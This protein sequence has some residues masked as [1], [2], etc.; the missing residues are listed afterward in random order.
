LRAELDPQ[1]LCE[2]TAGSI[3]ACLQCWGKLVQEKSW[4][5]LTSPPSLRES[6]RSVTASE[7]RQPLTSGIYSHGHTLYPST[8]TPH[9]TTAMT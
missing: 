4:G 7:E 2:K 3:V 5:S 9:H 1:N 6:L 8:P